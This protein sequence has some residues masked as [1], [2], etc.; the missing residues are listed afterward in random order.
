MGATSSGYCVWIE[1]YQGAKTKLKERYKSFGLGPSVIL[2]YADILKMLGSFPYHIFFDNFFTTV[3][4]LDQLQ[5]DNVRATGT[6]RENRMSKC[7]ILSK[8][9]IKK[10]REENMILD[11]LRTK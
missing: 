1:P 9:E 11:L 5:K 2:E 10:R 8:N 6:I 4:L 3:P 7:P